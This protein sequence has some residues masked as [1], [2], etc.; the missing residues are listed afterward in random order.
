MQTVKYHFSFTSPNIE[1]TS[2][3]LYILIEYQMN[4][5]ILLIN[6]ES[7]PKWYKNKLW[8]E[9]RRVKKFINKYK[10]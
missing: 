6:D 4:L 5:D 10:I 9:S 2:E 7:I 3:Q 1:I 8:A